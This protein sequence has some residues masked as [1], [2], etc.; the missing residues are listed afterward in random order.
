MVICHKVTS[1]FSCSVILSG[2]GS[3]A[4]AKG[5][6]RSGPKHHPL[7]TVGEE[8][9]AVLAYTVFFCWCCWLQILC[10]WECN[11]LV[12]PILRE[13]FSVFDKTLKITLQ[14]KGCII[15]ININS[16]KSLLKVIKMKGDGYRSHHSELTPSSCVN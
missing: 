12:A 3:A 13:N 8:N 2:G 4:R 9:L 5:S 6:S 15:I 16:N 14:R 1:W 10:V 11:Y 7:A